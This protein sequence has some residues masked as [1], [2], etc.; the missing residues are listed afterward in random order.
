MTVTDAL[1]RALERSGLR[2]SVY[3]QSSARGTWGLRFDHE[4]RATFHVVTSGTCWLTA[5]KA[6]VQL[7]VGDVLL[8]PRAQRYAIGDRPNPRTIALNE[9]LVQARP[10]GSGAGPATRVICGVYD[11][12]VMIGRHPILQLFPDVIHLR[13]A[14][15]SRE[16][17]S[18]LSALAAEFE[19]P[20]SG[21]SL[22]VSRLL[23]VMF[24]QIV[25]AW[26][27]TSP[28]GESRWLGALDDDLLARALGLLHTE[29]GR[30][31]SVADLAKTCGTSSSTLTRKF[32]AQVGEPPL[33]HLARIRMQEAARLLRSQPSAGLAAVAS[34]VGYSSEFA[35]NRAFRRE[36]G[37]PPGRYRAESLA[38][39]SAQSQ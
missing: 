21:S 25:R 30:D 38:Q 31:W 22:V 17:S 37:V 27:E 4:A 5:G 15:G 23:D 9:W 12:D 1:T 16:L 29:P 7:V 39:P 28:R 11:S 13:D 18:T 24:V 10:L 34:A 3:C 35:F 26:V 32:A 14:G 19:R 20:A 8:L 6:H 33:A 36:L 2:G